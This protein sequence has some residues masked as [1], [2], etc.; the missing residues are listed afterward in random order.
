MMEAEM[1]LAKP[2]IQKIIFTTKIFI[3]MDLKIENYKII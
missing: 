2:K 3:S 1:L